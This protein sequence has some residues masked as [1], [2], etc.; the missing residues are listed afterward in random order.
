MGYVEGD[1]PLVKFLLQ[2]RMASYTEGAL[3]FFSNELLPFKILPGL[4]EQGLY[5]QGPPYNKVAL[6]GSHS[7]HV[8]CFTAQNHVLHALLFEP[9]T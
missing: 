3:F 8:L 9:T 7:A 5:E 2:Q 6:H 1:L 4:Y